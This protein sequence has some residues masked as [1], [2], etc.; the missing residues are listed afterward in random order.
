M[1]ALEAMNQVALGAYA[2]GNLVAI[3]VIRGHSRILWEVHTCILPEYRGAT[4]DAAAKA[5]IAYVFEHGCLKLITLVPSFNRAAMLFA[6]HA[7][8][9]M[10]GTLKASFQKGGRL[11][12]QALLS[13]NKEQPCQ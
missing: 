10:E 3:F 13:V 8:L 9:R 12:D 7:G 2:G 4:A 5:L 11:Y 6:L 1:K